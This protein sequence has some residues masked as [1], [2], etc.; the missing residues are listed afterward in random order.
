MLAIGTYLPNFVLTEH[1]FFQKL[2]LDKISNGGYHIPLILRYQ[3]F[4]IP[5]F[6][7]VPRLYLHVERS[8]FYE[9][10]LGKSTEI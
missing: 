4:H 6:F 10:L 3:M 9:T 7:F 8:I 2:K 5:F 1:V